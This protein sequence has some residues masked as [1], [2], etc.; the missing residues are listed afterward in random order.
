LYLL[1]NYK[2]CPLLLISPMPRNPDTFPPIWGPSLL[3]V[4]WNPDPIAISIGRIGSIR[5]VI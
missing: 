5:R 1:N 3:P 4:A 2:I